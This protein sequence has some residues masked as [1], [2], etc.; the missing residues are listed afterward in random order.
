MV[1]DVLKKGP[2]KLGGVEL[3]V[4][5]YYDCLGRMST[6]DA[7]TPHIPKPVTVQLQEPILKFIFGKGKN[8]KKKLIKELTKVK[9]NLQWPD[10]FQTTQ[11]R[12]EPLL[13]DSQCQSSWI[14]WSQNATEVLTDFLKGCKSVTIP[15]PHSLWNDATAK[16]NETDTKCS[17]DCNNHEVILVGEHQD[18]DSKEDNIKK[19]IQKLKD[20]AD[21]EAQQAKQDINWNAEKLQ[22][23]TL[24]GIKQKVQ[25]TYP[26]LKITVHSS[27]GK[28]GL[29][30]E[31]TRKTIREVELSMLRQMCSL[32]HREFKAG[33]I[34]VRFVQHVPDKI[35]EI[36]G[37]QNIQAACRGSDDGKIIIYGATKN[38][39]SQA[40]AY[41]DNNIDEDVILIKGQSAIAVLQG[42]KGTRLLDGINK[43]KFVMANINHNQQTGIIYNAPF[44]VSRRIN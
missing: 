18:V 15:I 29:T 16:L 17:V 4:E 40:K 39:V 10:G 6:V 37:S 31:G 3:S 5:A 11:A 30:L 24:C 41:I 25:Q 12:L 43:Q 21:F 8:T 34:K 14:N 38:D 19:I 44:K 9:A 20:Q 42:Q 22:L 23:F 35:H 33:S 36:L 1:L 27:Y 7:P 32:D 26:D 2:H 28:M 13:E